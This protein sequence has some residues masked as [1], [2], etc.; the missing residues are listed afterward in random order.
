M[1][2][3]VAKCSLTN[4]ALLEGDD[5]YINI[6]TPSMRKR[7]WHNDK[8][9]LVNFQNGVKHSIEYRVQHP[10]S[11]FNSFELYNPVGILL[12]GV[13]TGWSSFELDFNDPTTLA[14]FKLLSQYLIWDVSNRYNTIFSAKDYHAHFDKGEYAEAWALADE[15]LRFQEAENLF[16]SNGNEF[17]QLQYNVICADAFDHLMLESTQKDI[18]AD[19]NMWRDEKSTTLKEYYDYVVEY[20]EEYKNANRDTSLQK[21]ENF[22]WL[23]R[24]IAC[25]IFGTGSYGE[26]DLIPL[27]NKR[28]PFEDHMLDES[29]SD[30]TD[31]DDLHDILRRLVLVNYVNAAYTFYGVQCIP[32]SNVNFEEYDNERASKFNK[33]QRKVIDLHERRFHEDFLFDSP[34]NCAVIKEKDD[35]IIAQYFMTDVHVE[36]F[37]AHLESIGIAHFSKPV[38]RCVDRDNIIVYDSKENR[39]YFENDERFLQTHKVIY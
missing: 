13:Y 21:A 34:T 12:K 8:I 17:I 25:S 36:E 24:S 4:V 5:A 37:Y 16:I 29:I 18:Y 10:S 28:H 1:G 32:L 6:I 20:V 23:T 7:S 14:N 26:G 30:A 3:L 9:E 27:I 31:L 2:C 38:I 35:L 19:L 22:K 15:A 39:V 11:R 33:L